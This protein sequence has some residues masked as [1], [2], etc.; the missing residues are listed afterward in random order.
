MTDD[1]RWTLSNL[2]EPGALTTH[3]W[4]GH[5]QYLVQ[6]EGDR[7]GVFLVHRYG[8]RATPLIHLSRGDGGRWE[9]H[10]INDFQSF[11]GST[12]LEVLS[13]AVAASRG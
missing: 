3:F 11:E 6:P 9:G 12:H 10:G 4:V 5:D 7:W 13:R 2:P 1:P 8:Q